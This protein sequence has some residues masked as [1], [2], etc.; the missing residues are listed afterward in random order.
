M[1]HPQVSGIFPPPTRSDA[2]RAIAKAL[3]RIRSNGWSAEALA[4]ALECSSDTIQ[5]AS[6]E[7]T[8][9]GFDSLALLAYKFPEEWALIEPLWTCRVAEAPSVQD[10][11]ERIERELDAIRKEATPCA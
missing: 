7:K 9:I 10:R 11:I 6:N 4:D 3:L 1:R 5:R 2:L 8:L